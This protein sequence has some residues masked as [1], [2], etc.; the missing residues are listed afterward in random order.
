[1][2]GRVLGGVFT[3]FLWYLANINLGSIILPSPIDV[4]EATLNEV[5]TKDGLIAIYYTLYRFTTTYIVSLVV[6]VV[7]GISSFRN[8][9][10]EKIVF[11]LLRAVQGTPIISWILIALLW[12][13]SRMI[14]YFILSI[15]IVPIIA[16]STYGGLSST[17]KKLIEMASVYKIKEIDVYKKIYLPSTIK[18]L[19]V[20]VV[21]AANSSFKVLITAEIIGRIPSGVGNYMNNAWINID[22]AYLI[23]WTLVLIALASLLVRGIEN[24]YKKVFW[25]YL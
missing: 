18:Q 11:P 22:T 7:I 3:L 1:M 2:L 20:G 6:G 16:I 14:P 8:K 19:Y 24:I 5:A 17:D 15:F 21:L 10:I 12:F 13:S 25:R 23:A 9:K 4:L